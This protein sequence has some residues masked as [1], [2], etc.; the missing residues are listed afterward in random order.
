[1]K[2]HTFN[3]LISLHMNDRVLV[4]ILAQCVTLRK[5]HRF[6]DDLFIKLLR[7]LYSHFDKVDLNLI[8]KISR[9]FGLGCEKCLVVF[10]E[11]FLVDN[12]CTMD[13]PWSYKQAFTYTNIVCNPPADKPLDFVLMANMAYDGEAMRLEK[14]GTAEPQDHTDDVCSCGD[15]DCNRPF[16]HPEEE[17]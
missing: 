17:G 3:I 2:K 16:G 15:P 8:Y 13:T 5:W 10:N 12:D 6:D 14:Q 1:M 9:V 4:K 7:M 11:R